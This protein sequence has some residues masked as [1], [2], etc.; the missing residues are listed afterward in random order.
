[1]AGPGPPAS[2]SS[3]TRVAPSPSRTSLAP[4]IRP[5]RSTVTGT[6]QPPYPLCSRT[7]SATTAE[8]ASALDGADTVA[9]SMSLRNASLPTP[10]V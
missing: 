8:P 5:S 4:T 9:T 7:T 2:K 6:V 3:R 10:T 1:M